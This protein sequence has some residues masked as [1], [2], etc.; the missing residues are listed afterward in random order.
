MIN[1]GIIGCGSI[2]RQR[3]AVEYSSNPDVTIL[4][5]NDYHQERAEYMTQEFGGKVYLEQ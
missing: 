2:A 4:G 3:H 5:F 1:V